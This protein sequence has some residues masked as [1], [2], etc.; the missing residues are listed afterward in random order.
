[1]ITVLFDIVNGMFLG[2]SLLLLS[3]REKY[4][5]VV[6]VKCAIANTILNYYLIPIQLAR[7][8]ALNTVIFPILMFVLL[9]V[10]IDKRIFRCIC[11]KMLFDSI[12]GCI[13]IVFICFFI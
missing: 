2:N 1:M 9:L 4:F 3:G 7:A 12:A 6:C 5:M 11:E 13:F 8:A 10:W